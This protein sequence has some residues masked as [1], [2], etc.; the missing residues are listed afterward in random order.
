MTRPQ[1]LLLDEV[2]LIGR[3]PDPDLG[4]VEVIVLGTT[5]SDQSWQAALGYARV[6]I[7]S[8]RAAGAPDIGVAVIDVRHDRQWA[9][10]GLRRLR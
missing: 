7:E 1:P 6:L 5:G 3:H 8:A 10:K 4:G 9:A 2:V